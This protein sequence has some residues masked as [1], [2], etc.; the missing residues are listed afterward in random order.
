MTTSLHLLRH[1]DAA[2]AEAWA[3]S[4]DDRPL[5]P[6]G[7]RQAERLARLLRRAGLEPDAIVSSPKVRARETAELI[8]AE[9]G[10][11]VTIDEA[12]GS[13]PGLRELDAAL[14]AAGN[15]ARPILVGHDP[16]F[17]ELAAALVGAP[18]LPMRKGALVRIDVDRPLAP[19]GGTL[20]WLVPPD[21][22][23]ADD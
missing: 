7:R 13:A 22:L 15:P 2:A 10:R 19:G 11:E 18:D 20:R 14:S 4:D 1:G 8:A 12:L 9:L 17:S 21:L 6:E 23:A 3:G 16:E 5:S